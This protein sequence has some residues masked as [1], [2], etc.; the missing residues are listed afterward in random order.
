M[1]EAGLGIYAI[2]IPALLM[3]LLAI[4]EII[5]PRLGLVL[6]RYP[7]WITH[8]LFFLTN[9]VVGRLLSTILVVGIAATWASENNFGLLNLVEWPSLAEA[10]IAFII[11]DFAMWL[12]HLAMH[13]Y[14]LLWRL[15]AVHHSDRDLDVTT[16]LRFHPFELIVSTL[17]KSA[18]VA[19]L[20][21]PVLVA[22]AFELWLN[23]NALFNHSNIKLPSR[24]DRWLRR[25]LVTPDMHLIHHSILPSDQ[26]HN[27]GFA[28]TI[29]DRIFGTFAASRT[30]Q[31]VGLASAQDKRPASVFWSLAQPF[32]KFN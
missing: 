22:L 20:G 30:K 27:Y 24:A 5:W 10:A 21:V 31:A 28:L 2:A 17:Y 14:P 4:A 18:W 11:L 25:V 19:L 29:W 7:R 23:A 26:H 1:I 15:H 16:A 8:A 32:R 6:G 3:V 13:R 12:Q 9:A